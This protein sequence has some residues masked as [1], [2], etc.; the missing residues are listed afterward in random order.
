MQEV[1][2]LREEDIH[3]P[4]AGTGAGDHSSIL[5]ESQCTH[6]HK[7]FNVLLY[8][9]GVADLVNVNAALKDLSDWKSLGLELGLLLPTL[10]RIEEEQRGVIVKCKTE[11]LAAWLRQQDNVAKRCLPSCDTLKVALGNIGENNLACELEIN[12][13]DSVAAPSCD[14][15]KETLRNIGENKLARELEINGR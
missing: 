6:V 3:S 8:T 15:L 5:S 13:Q 1:A 9:S 2:G 11:M 4:T 12:G 14:T 10:N 7:L